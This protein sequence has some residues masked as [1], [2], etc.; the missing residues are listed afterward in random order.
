MFVAR[1]GPGGKLGGAGAAGEWGA[2]C[3]MLLG[4][5]GAA[6]VSISWVKWWV[7]VHLQ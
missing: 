6:E 5:L 2:L 3:A 7:V 1:P 4:R